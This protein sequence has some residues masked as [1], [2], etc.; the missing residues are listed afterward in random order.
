MQ[1][2]VPPQ[3]FVIWSMDL[4]MYHAL[5]DRRGCRLLL[6]EAAQ[7]AIELGAKLFGIVASGVSIGTALGIANELLR[8]ADTTVCGRG[9]GVAACASGVGIVFDGRHDQRS[10][11]AAWARVWR[12]SAREIAAAH[13]RRHSMAP[14]DVVAGLVQRSTWAAAS[15]RVAGLA[16]RRLQWLWRH[17]PHSAGPRRRGRRHG[18]ALRRT[19][20][21]P[22]AGS[23]PQHPHSGGVACFECQRRALAARRRRGRGGERGST[24]EEIG[25]E[26]TGGLASGRGGDGRLYS[27]RQIGPSVRV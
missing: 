14:L 15:M 10:T 9:H 8:A 13:G 27:L 21:R 20:A 4:E 7:A 17:S 5:W 1:P 19:R 11:A 18:G 24:N 23:M 22:V 25:G 2:G 12:A 16:S 26:L 3:N 6:G